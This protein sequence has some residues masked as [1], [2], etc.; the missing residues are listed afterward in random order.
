M[1]QSQVAGSHVVKVDLGVC[2]DGVGAVDALQLVVHLVDGEG[3]AAAGVG[4]EAEPPSEHVDAHDAEDQPEDEAHQQHVHDGGDGAH[5]RVHHHLGSTDSATVS[6]VSK[7]PQKHLV[8]MQE[9][10][11]R[12]QRLRMQNMSFVFF[13]ICFVC[14]FLITSVCCCI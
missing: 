11:H 14:A 8:H 10:L 13:I 2:P 7:G 12:V 3:E 5:Q 6:A 9:P 4:A 1:Q